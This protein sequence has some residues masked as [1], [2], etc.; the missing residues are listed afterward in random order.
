MRDGIKGSRSLSKPIRFRKCTSSRNERRMQ[1]IRN[2]VHSGNPNQ[3]SAYAAALPGD[4][5][6]GKR[7]HD[8]NCMGCHDTGSRADIA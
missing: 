3:P 5:A 4:S 2:V 8:A 7:L 1:E 6:E